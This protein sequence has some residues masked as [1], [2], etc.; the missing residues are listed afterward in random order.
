MFENH[1]CSLQ[2]K[3]PRIK[4]REIEKK[5]DFVAGEKGEAPMEF[6]YLLSAVNDVIEK[7]N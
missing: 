7:E 6:A 4:S 3:W 1:S 2:I 5:N